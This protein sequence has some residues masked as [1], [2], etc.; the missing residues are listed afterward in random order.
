MPLAFYS[1]REDHWEGMDYQPG[2]HPPP[3]WHWNPTQKGGQEQRYA[4]LYAN[5]QNK[6]VWQ[7]ITRKL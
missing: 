3:E 5:R 2:T 1:F 4:E 7:A 6:E